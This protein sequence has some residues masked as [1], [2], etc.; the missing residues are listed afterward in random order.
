MVDG[1][2][3]PFFR[4]TNNQLVLY[5]SP[6]PRTATKSS[7][8]G[9]LRYVLGRSYLMQFAVIRLNALNWWV[10][11]ARNK[12]EYGGAEGLRVTCWLMKTVADLGKATNVRIG[13]VLQYGGT[14][15]TNTAPEWD[16]PALLK[17]INDQGLEV[18]DTFEALRSVYVNNGPDVYQRLWVMHE[19][20]RIYGHMS[21]TGNRLI[22]QSIAKK[23]FNKKIATEPHS[24]TIEI[25]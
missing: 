6:V 23:F 9:W 3:K 20:G 2:P 10:A 5:N 24:E 1:V 25:R 17:C 22:A 4:I 13:I 18:I 16:R 19:N 8:I 11:S 21:A 12:I 14:E 7:E 15:A